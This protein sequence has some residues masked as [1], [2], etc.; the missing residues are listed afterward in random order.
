MHEHRYWPGY[1]FVDLARW[2]KQARHDVSK[3]TR[4]FQMFLAV[5][6]TS[7]PLPTR[8]LVI[9]IIVNVEANCVDRLHRKVALLITNKCFGF[10]TFGWH[11]RATWNIDAIAILHRERRQS[12]CTFNNYFFMSNYFTKSK[13]KKCVI[14]SK[15][16]MSPC[17]CELLTLLVNSTSC[18]KC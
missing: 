4:S 16:I 17:V 10:W 2:Q 5:P 8:L 9:S 3:Q 13:A 18:R 6:P 15:L 1:T 11:L 7:T 14:M 12:K